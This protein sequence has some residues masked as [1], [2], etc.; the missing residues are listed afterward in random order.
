MFCKNTN[1]FTLHGLIETFHGDNFLLQQNIEQKEH[2]T[3]SM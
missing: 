2:A 1:S 3:P